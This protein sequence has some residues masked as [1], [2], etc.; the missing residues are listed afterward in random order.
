MAERRR[1][2]RYPAELPVDLM[3]RK[4][5]RRVATTDVGRHGIFVRMD[6][7]PAERLL[8]QLKLHLPA[9]PVPI[10]AVVARRVL[11]GPGR[12]AGAG[13]QFFVLAPDAKDQ[14]DAYVGS[15]RGERQAAPDQ[16]EAPR[17]LASFLVRL[18]DVSRLREVYTRDI[19]DGGM[20]VSTPLV[21][22]LGSEVSLV[23]VHP[24]SDEEYQLVGTVVRIQEGPPK[25]MGIRLSG[26]GGEE[27]EAFRR[28]VETGVAALRWRG[29]AQTRPVAPVDEVP[30][31][32]ADEEEIDLG[33][34][35]GATLDEEHGLSSIED[36]IARSL[37]VEV[38]DPEEAL[39]R[40]EIDRDPGALEP[41]VRL[42]ARLLANGQVHQAVETAEEAVA[43]DP[44]HPVA[45]IGLAR[46]LARM[47]RYAEAHETFERA[48]RHGHP[49]DAKLAAAIA[50][51]L[52]RARP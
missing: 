25:G 14:W 39:L 10:L 13:L 19:S 34:L 33:D 16:R 48:R 40:E 26:F 50:G 52:G 32:P 43:L 37:S 28:F 24:A 35:D 51:G 5:D 20:F 9:G 29:S 11:P 45:L 15:L 30:P 6:D 8:V 2:D 41:R 4:G 17:R 31:G 47:E 23:V 38:P 21:R 49:G 7:P 27:K 46:A 22:P 3:E 42:A 44:D 36:E 12:V 1:S 18:R